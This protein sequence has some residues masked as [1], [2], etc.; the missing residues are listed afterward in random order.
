MSP[1]RQT[2]AVSNVLNCS[3]HLYTQAKPNAKAK[4]LF[5]RSSTPTS[6]KD[7]LTTTGRLVIQ[8]D[9]GNHPP[10]FHAYP[11]S[12]SNST[13]PLEHQEHGCANPT[14]ARASPG[15]TTVPSRIGSNSGRRSC[16]R[17]IHSDHHAQP[18]Y[19][20]TSS[21]RSRVYRYNLARPG[22]GMFLDNDTRS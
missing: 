19:N 5:H 1:P 12:R 11:R 8:S 6:N 18:V 20:S 9:G 14:K 15:A 7:R 3:T 13:E 4:I 10:P 2:S 21:P 16:L 22:R 17:L